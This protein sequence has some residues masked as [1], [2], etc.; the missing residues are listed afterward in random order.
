[1]QLR[2]FFFHGL[3]PEGSNPSQQMISAPDLQSVANEYNILFIL[4]VSQVWDLVGQRFHLWNIEQGTEVDDLTLYDDLRTCVSEHF[5]V[6]NTEQID[7]DTMSSIGF[8]GG[9]Y[10]PLW[11]CQTAL[12]RLASVVEMSGGADLQVPGLRILFLFTILVVEMC[13]HC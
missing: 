12:K 13:Q 5:D 4:P 9:A 6:Y 1:M 10:L 3:M 8:S 2:S 11:C 7:L